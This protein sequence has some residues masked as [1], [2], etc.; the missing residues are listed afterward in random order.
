[1][2]T[3]SEGGGRSRNLSSP[4]EDRQ[5]ARRLRKEGSWLGK[6]NNHTG[7]E[8]VGDPEGKKSKEVILKRADPKDSNGGG[9]ASEV[10]V[11]ICSH[12]RDS[13]RRVGRGGDLTP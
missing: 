1:M 4:Q 10:G 12:P 6:Q 3:G 11:K 7:E 9:G 8:E 2:G 5:E 13:G